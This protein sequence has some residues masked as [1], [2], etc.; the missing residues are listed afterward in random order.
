MKT[1]LTKWKISS[2]NPLTLFVRTLPAQGH[3]GGGKQ[4]QWTPWNI[5][6][7][8]GNPRGEVKTPWPYRGPRLLRLEILTACRAARSL[9][10]GSF[11][12][13]RAPRR[14]LQRRYGERLLAKGPD[15]RLAVVVARSPVAGEVGPWGIQCHIINGRLGRNRLLPEVN[16]EESR[17]RR[18]REVIRRRSSQRQMA[19]RGYEATTTGGRCLGS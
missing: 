3:Y 10:L 5:N 13:W 2:H 16:G 11:P 18:L 4:H 19:E 12:W 7:L 17:R 6:F 14:Q 1:N 9:F 8:G 15:M